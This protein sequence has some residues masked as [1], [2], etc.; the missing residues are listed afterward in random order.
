M[1]HTS[2]SPHPPLASCRIDPARRVSSE[3]RPGR[4]VARIARVGRWGGYH[5]CARHRRD[6]QPPK[7]RQ[8]RVWR[9]SY[10][11]CVARQDTFWRIPRVQRCRGPA[12]VAQSLRLGRG[13]GTTIPRAEGSTGIRRRC[14]PGVDSPPPHR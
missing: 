5:P 12:P 14:D 1:Q 8:S 11:R 7:G 2:G 10:H 6:P 9:P 13:V 3:K 4:R